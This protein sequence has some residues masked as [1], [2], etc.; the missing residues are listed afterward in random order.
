MVLMQLLAAGW[1]GRGALSRAQAS[2][3]LPATAVRTRFP[4]VKWISL[5][6]CG[7]FSQ[8]FRH[9]L[10]CKDSHR[11]FL[12]LN[13]WHGIFSYPPTQKQACLHVSTLG[14]NKAQWEYIKKTYSTLQL[15]WKCRVSFQNTNFSSFGWKWIL[16]KQWKKWA[17][18]EGMMIV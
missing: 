18:S 12:L 13:T 4:G 16:S 6:L 14:Q 2:V 11:P 8:P 15:T 10:S 5:N 7:I 1:C 3:Y 9:F 17:Q